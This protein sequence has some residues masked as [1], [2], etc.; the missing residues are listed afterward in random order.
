MIL[1]LRQGRK[2]LKTASVTLAVQPLPEIGKPTNFSGAIGEYQISAQTERTWVEAGSA[3]SLSVRISGRG[4]MQTV[5]APKLPAIT[6]V[7]VNGPNLSQD[8]MP[9]SRLYVY[10][11]TPAHT[12]TLHIPAIVY[13]YFNPSRAVYATTQT[14]PIPLSVRPNPNDA[15]EIETDDTSWKFWVILS[16]A[17]VLAIGLIVGFIWYRAGFSRATANTAAQTDIDGN[18]PKRG[19]TQR[20]ETQSETPAT[21]ALAALAELR[22]NDRHCG[23]G[24]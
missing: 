9:T 12:G 6:G 14:A 18:L 21:Q 3:L 11:L 7:V 2:T 13:T 22:N 10:T 8:S 16:S 5:T 15:I 24:F 17:I 1:P 23:R 19:R 4:N 20:T